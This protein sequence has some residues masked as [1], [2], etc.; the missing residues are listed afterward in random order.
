MTDVVTIEGLRHTYGRTL[1]LD[2]VDLTVAP[3]E[4][5]ALLGPNGAGKTTLVNALTG[6]QRPTAGRVEI[7]GDDPQRAETRKRI[8]VVQQSV[9]F[10]RTL[11]VGELVAGWAVRYG[12]TASAAEPVLRE[13]GI[14]DLR[15]RRTHKLSGGQQQRLQL[16]MALVADPTLLVLDEPTAGLDVASRRAFWRILAAR[17]ARGAAVLLTTH[18][19]EEAAATADRVV[20]LHEGRV[21]AEGSPIELTSRLPD[22][23]IS[24]RTTLDEPHLHKL[25]GVVDVTV[26]AGRARLTSTAPE[27]A[28]RT[29]LDADPYLTDLRVEAAS[30]EE[31]VVSIT[32]GTTTG[33]VS[34]AGATEEVPA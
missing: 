31:A 15:G 34:G 13:L 20:V 18:Q 24:A 21:V 17:R 7:D 26:D 6:L 1:A 9:G 8:G 25:P 5:V 27:A 29:L 14:T 11:T 32:A 30:L 2:G 28:V 12:R 19:I 16:A 33:G 10:P 23:S 22:R 4:C 3:G